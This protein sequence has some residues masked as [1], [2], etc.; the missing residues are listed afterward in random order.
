MA[1]I[2]NG[3]QVETLKGKLIE[4]KFAVSD[5]KRYSFEMWII[6]DTKDRLPDESLSYLSLS[7]IISI[8]D[9]IN[10]VIKESLKLD[11]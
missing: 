7:E 4:V 1:E 2:K 10:I 9:E 5:P 3:G 11:D 8:R 6:S